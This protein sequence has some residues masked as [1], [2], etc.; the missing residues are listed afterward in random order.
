MRVTRRI[1]ARSSGATRE[2]PCPPLA[3]CRIPCANFRRASRSTSAWIDGQDG[4]QFHV[5]GLIR[6]QK[7]NH[8]GDLLRLGDLPMCRRLQ[9]TIT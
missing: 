2:Y 4:E 5:A 8:G 9:D 7:G 3:C 6:S 1:G